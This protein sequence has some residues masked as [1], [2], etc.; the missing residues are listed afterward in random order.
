[1]CIVFYTKITRIT[2]RQNKVRRMHRSLVIRLHPCRTYFRKIS[3][4]RERRD[5]SEPKLTWG[6]VRVKKSIVS[7]FRDNHLNCDACLHQIFTL[8]KH[9]FNIILRRELEPFIPWSW[10]ISTV[11]Q[12]H[13]ITL[14]YDLWSIK[15]NQS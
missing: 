5:I 3:V 7:K 9:C 13:L 14:W 11:I 15:T 1:M 10:F 6:D 4:S 8:S 2:F 12:L